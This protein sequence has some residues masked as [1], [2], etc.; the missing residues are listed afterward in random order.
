[1]AIVSD[2]YQDDVTVVN[3][4]YDH[5]LA[6]LDEDADVEMLMMM[7]MMTPTLLVMS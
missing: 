7:M 5:Y 3:G 4:L 6:D 2:V 1:L